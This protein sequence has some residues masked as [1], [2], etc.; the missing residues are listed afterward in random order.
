MD[1]GLEVR[2]GTDGWR[3][4]IAR[5]V[6]VS[7]VRAVARAIIAALKADRADSRRLWLVVG[8][9]T[10][11]LSRRFAE[12]AAETLRDGAAKV[13]MTASHVPTPTLAWSVP[14][15]GA[16]AGLM[17][18]AS[19]NPPSY[20]GLKVRVGDGGPPDG[21]LV[22]LVEARVGQLATDDTG[23]RDGTCSGSEG[24]G[25]IDRFDP[26][27][28]YRR[29][30]RSLIDTE[31]IARSGLRVVVDPMYGAAQGLVADLL[32]EIGLQVEE[33]R[34]EV[35]PWFGGVA[36]EPL[37]ESL[38]DLIERVVRRPDRRTVGLAFDGDGDRLAAVDERGSFVN[39]H[40]IFALLLRHLV[41]R[42]GLSGR[43]VKT[44]STSRMIDRLAET[45]GVPLSVTP[46]G[47]K[48]I[49]PIMRQGSCL[50]GG[51]E[52]GGIGW[53]AH[54]PERDGVLSALLLLECIGMERKPLE[55]L[56][57]DLEAEVGPHCYR[58]LDV[59]LRRIGDREAVEKRLLQEALVGFDG[60]RVADVQTLDGVK[61]IGGDGS[62]LL[63]RSSGTEPVLRLYAEASSEMLA[64]RLIDWGRARANALTAGL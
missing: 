12:V 40:Q 1:P 62:W 47:F 35:N 15:L 8:H 52:S 10:R 29:R 17:V 6:T 36:P 46:I 64:D 56:V 63:I 33:T 18:T 3:G 25:S 39:P 43:V 31:C 59:G 28:A 7:T 54:I 48:H 21:S 23:R 51:E 20:S 14:Y 42:R 24:T 34:G 49:A 58:R 22:G 16:D 45:Y 5:D 41:I 11:F 38:S 30:L 32:R 13:L 61:L 19:H 60:W 37:A 53:T 55:T 2:F 44:F 57:R 26:L 27:P 4:V 50:L 9:D